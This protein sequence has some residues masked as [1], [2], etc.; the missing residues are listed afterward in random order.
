MKMNSNMNAFAARLLAG[1]AISAIAATGAAAQSDEIVVTATKR[2][3]TLQEVPIAVSVVGAE[4][5]QKAQIND[6]IDLQT[7]V[8][9]LRVTQLQNSSQTNFTIRGFGNGANNPGIESSVGVFIDGVYRSRSAAA[10]LDLPTLERVE[11]LRG[12]QSTLFGKNV[13]AG[14][15]SITTKLP[16]FDWS[17]NVEASYG[18]YDQMLFKGTLSGP[19]SDNVAFRVSGSANKR[20]GYYTNIVDGTDQNERNRW[21]LRGQLLWEASDALTFRVIG[22]YNKIDENCC[23]AVTILNGPATQ[24]LAAPPPFGLGEE[25]SDGT[26]PFSRN[27]AV[28][29]A[30]DNKLTGK[31]ISLQAD[32]ELGDGFAQLTSITAYR[33]QSDTAN[34]DV[35]FSGADLAQNPQDRKYETFTQEIRLSSVGDNRFD[36]M[37]GAFYFNE[38]VFLQRD[39]IFGAQERAN[40]DFLIS[41]AGVSLADVEGVS[42]LAQALTTGPGALFP[43]FLPMGSAGVDSLAFG[44]S[45]APGTGVFGTYN[46]DNESYSFFGQADFEITDRLTISGGISYIDDS[47]SAT[48]VSNL[49]DVF[50]NFDLSTFA[51]TGGSFVAANIFGGLIPGAYGGP[52]AFDPANPVPFFTAAGTFAALDPL[53]F[54]ATRDGAVAAAQGALTGDPTL[55]P[56]LGLTGLTAVQFF[57]PQTNFPDPS[58]PFDDGKLDSNDV[59]WT[60]RLAYDVTDN[61]NA[62]FTYA[63]GYKAGAFNLSSDSRPPVDASKLGRA[64]SPEDVR[65]FE[66]GFKANFDGGYVNIALF[67]QKIEGFQSNVFNGVGFDLANAGEQTSRGFEVESLYSPWNPLAL[68]FALTYLDPEYKSFTM[69]GC[70]PFDVV[71]CGMGESFRD[72]S[73]TRVPGVHEVS[74]STSAT[75]SF[76]VNDNWGGYARIEYLYESDVPL[77]ENIPDS[78]TREVNVLNASIGFE[79]QDGFEVMVWGRNLTDDEYFLQGFPTVAQTG[80]VSGYTNP[81]RTYGVT[82]RKSF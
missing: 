56:L 81:P 33:E 44:S 60:A 37:V 48:G 31:G 82:V 36:W 80:S 49:T 54:A 15:I 30:T 39:V 42:Q 38:D 55:N 66:L 26:D 72:L 75:Y 50:S 23:G 11:V 3:Q 71:N 64:A 63:T 76:D 7:V 40:I 78:I 21:A 41:G 67:D 53:V 29:T 34:T 1:A 65:L 19:L 16:T 45:F 6:L 58:N 18:N 24:V 59:T 22:D 9:S 62:Y 27:V 74:L 73:G 69:A 47:K 28:D 2:P 77:I 43:E 17:G 61:F 79:T 5:I 25:I 4:T 46:M 52:V 12:P 51:S 20:D 8:P 14:A 32:W 57:A 70:T 13:S 35:D 10:I 68:T